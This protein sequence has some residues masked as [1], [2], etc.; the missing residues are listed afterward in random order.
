[1]PIPGTTPCGAKKR[2]GNPCTQPAMP[3][4]RCKMHRGKALSG[5]AHPNLTTGRYSKNLPTRMMATY[6]ERLADGNSLAL[7]DDLALLDSRLEDV[8]AK[9]DTG[10]TGETWAALLDAAR[11]F[12]KSERAAQSCANE[13]K[14]AEYKADREEA[15]RTILVLCQAGMADY[16][17]WAEVKSL[18]EQ[19]RKAVETETKRRVLMQHLMTAEQA[20]LMQ[21]AVLDIIKRNVTD[22][23]TLAAIAADFGR[24]AVSGVC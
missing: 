16:S 6:Q 20:T 21:A 22:R 7:N 1:M 14:K 13:A 3:N 11:E 17:A 24:L 12:E 18:L 23:P 4:G 15:M 19:R 10:E 2:D 8:L 5:I 9:V